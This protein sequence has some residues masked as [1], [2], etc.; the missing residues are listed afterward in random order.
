VK[1]VH[2]LPTLSMGGLRRHVEQLISGATGHIDHILIPI[3]TLTD[4]PILPIGDAEIIP[5][6]FQ[7]SDIPKH[8]RIRDVLIAQLDKHRVDVVHSHHVYSDIYAFA[9]IKEL[10]RLPGIRTVH[11]ILQVSASSGLRKTTVRTSWSD[12]EI[13]NQ[14]AVEPFCQ[15]TLCVSA[16]VRRKVLSFG[17][18]GSKARVIH[19]GVDTDLHSPASPRSKLTARQTIRLPIDSIVIGFMGRLE[20][21]KNVFALFE[22]AFILRKVIDTPV[23]FLVQGEGPEEARFRE[24][25]LQHELQDYFFF[26]APSLD[27]EVFF[28]AIDVMLV[29]SLSEGCPY[30]VLEAMASGVPVVASAAGG[31]PEIIEDG[32]NGFLFDPAQPHLAIPKIVSLFATQFR[33][34]VG[35]Q[36]RERVLD[37]FRAGDMV[38]AIEHSYAEVLSGLG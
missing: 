10:P 18:P 7:I 22:I 15:L 30:A 32:K 16:W 31:I 26:R 11:G 33:N 37:R 2:V 5:L 19:N 6:G 1:V 17:I 35:R 20:P 24:R 12:S 27:T 34:K 14:I 9:A 3:F 4:R 25:I 36:S 38:S 13:A 21:A 28:S 29:P 8:E 23:A